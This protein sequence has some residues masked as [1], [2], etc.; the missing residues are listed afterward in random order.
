MDYHDEDITLLR[1]PLN[2]S[3]G[4]WLGWHSHHP[5]ME[6]RARSPRLLS[7]RTLTPKILT[8]RGKPPV[9]RS[10]L[11]LHPA[12]ARLR[13]TRCK[14][15]EEYACGSTWSCFYP[16]PCARE[17]VHDSVGKV[18][19]AHSFYPCKKWKW[20][21]TERLRARPAWVFT[22]LVVVPPTPCV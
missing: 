7:R 19:Q 4:F 10:L 3:R 16:W 22:Q 8:F 11:L 14:R 18:L 15:R 20:G 9:F 6:P 13:T 2:K 5:S 21:Q 17:P 12:S 1:P